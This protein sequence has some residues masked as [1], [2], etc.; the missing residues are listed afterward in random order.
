MVEECSIDD[1]L[2][3]GD[4]VPH[5]SVVITCICLFPIDFSFCAIFPN[6]V[7]LSLGILCLHSFADLIIINAKPIKFD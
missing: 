7:E 4:C 1:V 3:S 2:G 6:F 5:V